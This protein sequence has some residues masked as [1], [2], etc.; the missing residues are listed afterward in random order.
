MEPPL[1]DEE[2][3][4]DGVALLAPEPED[5]P[6]DAPDDPAEAPEPEAVGAGA[7]GP[8]IPDAMLCAALATLCAALCTDCIAAAPVEALTPGG[9]MAW[10]VMDGEGAPAGAAEAAV[11]E[12]PAEAELA[13]GAAPPA[14]GAAGAAAADE[15]PSEPPLEA[16]PDGPH[17]PL[18]GASLE[19]SPAIST[20]APGFGNLTSIG[21]PSLSV[22]Q[23][24]P[25]LALNMSGKEVSRLK[26]WSEAYVSVAFKEESSSRSRRV[27]PPPETEIGAQFMYISR[28]PI[29][30]NHVQASVYS[31]GA[32]P[33]GILYWN[34]VALL[35]L[36]LSGRLPSAFAGQPP[37]ILW[38][39]IHLESFVGLASFVSEIWQE[40]PPWTAL[41]LK[42]SVCGAPMAIFVAPPGGGL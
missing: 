40:P 18:G 29:W 32:I 16:P 33:C 38:I 3:P 13:T 35:P 41:P 5:S 23:P 28:L 24:L 14:A 15:L 37:S 19:G 20:E 39:T 31:P 22:V 4:D 8:T 9:G 11:F 30:L 26:I 6:D 1:D 34:C 42:D 21:F 27:L 17:E 12:P 36:G 10:M 7:A 2:A 25:M